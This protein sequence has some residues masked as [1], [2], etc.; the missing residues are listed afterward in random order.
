MR[1]LL[2]ILTLSILSLPLLVSGVPTPDGDSGDSTA[3]RA[4]GIDVGSERKDIDW[5]IMRARGYLFAYI[6]ATEGTS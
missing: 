5:D 2:Q 6:E 1:S 4:M 3:E